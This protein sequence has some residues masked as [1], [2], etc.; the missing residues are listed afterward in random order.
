MRPSCFFARAPPEK[1]RSI[2]RGSR[3]GSARARTPPSLEFLVMIR[4]LV[5]RTASAVSVAALLAAGTLAAPPSGQN[6]A[7]PGHHRV[8]PPAKPLVVTEIVPGIPE[9]ERETTE[10]G[11]GRAHGFDTRRHR[12]PN[13][14]YVRD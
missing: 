11:K 6:T 10:Q 1:S 13:G 9:R 3:A 4:F 14:E 12:K 8:A 5:I 2:A 7:P